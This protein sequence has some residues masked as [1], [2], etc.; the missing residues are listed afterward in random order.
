MA[1][2][3]DKLLTLLR[4]VFGWDAFRPVQRQVIDA[5]QQGSD[6]LARTSLPC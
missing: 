4:D 3:E 1:E 5:V 6:V 2:P